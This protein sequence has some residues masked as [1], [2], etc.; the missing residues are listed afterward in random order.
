MSYLSIKKD[1]LYY[2]IYRKTGNFLYKP[3]GNYNN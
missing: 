1:L 3:L 2:R